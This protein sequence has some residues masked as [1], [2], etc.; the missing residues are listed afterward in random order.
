MLKLAAKFNVT[1][2]PFKDKPLLNDGIEIY[3]EFNRARLV[4]NLPDYKGG[5][6]SKILCE[7]N[8]KDPEDGKTT[9]ILNDWMRP[10]VTKGTSGYNSSKLYNR[11]VLFGALNGFVGEFGKVGNITDEE[12]LN[13]VN[14]ALEGK[15]VKIKIKN[16]KKGTSDEYSCVGDIVEVI[17]KNTGEIKN[18]RKGQK[19]KGEE[20]D[21]FPEID[22]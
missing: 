12:L 10:R 5:K 7:Y 20:N 9:Y 16:R 21:R 13:Y 14:Q 4:E 3:G 2:R 1:D 19:S 17:D 11:L 6:T 15:I 8:V 18:T 22:R